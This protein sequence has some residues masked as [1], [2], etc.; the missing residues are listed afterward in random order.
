MFPNFPASGEL[1]GFHLRSEMVIEKSSLQP[2][3]G[4]K[5]INE[6]MLSSI[7]TL[8]VRRFR[9]IKK[10]VATLETHMTQ[11]GLFSGGRQK[12]YSSS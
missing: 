5:T 9:G 1:W 4:R 10:G 12:T 6:G 2:R 8:A 3:V 11:P 7:E